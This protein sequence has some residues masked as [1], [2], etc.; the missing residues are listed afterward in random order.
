MDLGTQEA[1]L[2]LVNQH[3]KDKLLVV[4]GA[5]ARAQSQCGPSI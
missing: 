3:G 4:L 1:I 5:P 2:R